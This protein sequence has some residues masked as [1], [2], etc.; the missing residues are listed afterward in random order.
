MTL[1]HCKV[2]A[3]CGLSKIVWSFFRVKYLL[4]DNIN[5]LSI[6]KEII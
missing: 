6:N 3:I 2:Q 1:N 4:N 5:K